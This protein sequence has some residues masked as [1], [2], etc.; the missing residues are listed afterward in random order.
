VRKVNVRGL[1]I[2][3]LAEVG[4]AWAKQ[5]LQKL[6]RSGKGTDLLEPI[7]AALR[8]IEARS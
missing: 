5:P 6:A 1:A 3:Q 8:A 7:A 2:E 4:G